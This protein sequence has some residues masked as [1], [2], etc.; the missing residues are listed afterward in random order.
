[1]IDFDF[2]VYVPRVHLSRG[3]RFFRSGFSALHFLHESLSGFPL[4]AGFGPGTGKPA[5]NGTPMGF[6][7][8]KGE[9]NRPGFPGLFGAGRLCGLVSGN[10]SGK[11]DG[12]SKANGPVLR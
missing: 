3:L 10:T 11:N 12:E 8:V 6:G 4:G 2:M 5:A 1:M 9:A 7:G